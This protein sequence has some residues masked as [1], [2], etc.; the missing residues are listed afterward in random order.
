MNFVT[1]RAF[2]CLQGLMTVRAFREQASFEARNAKL[3]DDSNRAYWPAQVRCWFPSFASTA[4]GLLL[5]VGCMQLPC[6]ALQGFVD[7]NCCS[8]LLD[9]SW[10]FFPRA[11]CVQCINRWLS[12]RLELL[13]IS[14]V[15]GTAVLVSV[16]AP[17]SAGLAGLALTSALNLTGLMNWMVRQTTELEVRWQAWHHWDCRLACLHCFA[18]DICPRMHRL[19]KQMLDLNGQQP[20]NLV[21]TPSPHFYAP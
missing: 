7:S 1:V 13:G 10:H 2:A 15:F 21:L 9:P 12:V 17:R 19:R 4:P 18:P 8:I 14:V 20:L 6:Q 5:L 16:A 3:M 11:M